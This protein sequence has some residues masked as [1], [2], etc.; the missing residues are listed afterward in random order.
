M[1]KLLLGLL[2]IAITAIYFG[3]CYHLTL[4]LSL[5]PQRMS[6]FIFSEANVVGILVIICLISFIIAIFTEGFSLKELWEKHRALM[7]LILLIV[8]CYPLMMMAVFSPSNPNF[9]YPLLILIIPDTLFVFVFYKIER[10]LVI[11]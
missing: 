8:F 2:L 5:Y 7:I 11:S 6:P 9:D 3:V 10:R 1:K 4:Y